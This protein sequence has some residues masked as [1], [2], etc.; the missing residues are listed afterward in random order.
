MGKVCISC[1]LAMPQPKPGAQP[2]TPPSCE[3]CPTCPN[4]IK[5]AE[6]KK[7]EPKK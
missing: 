6:A 4:C 3:E 5:K 7:N 1:G 2:S